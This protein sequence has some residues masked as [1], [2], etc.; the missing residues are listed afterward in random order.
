[1]LRLTGI[2]AGGG[3]SQPLSVTATSSNTG[4]IPHPV[5]NYTSASTTGSLALTPVANQSGT[6]T[7]TV[8]V[9]DGGLDNNLA[10]PGDNASFS[11]D[12]TVEVTPNETGSRIYQNFDE[13]GSPYQLIEPVVDASHGVL[14]NGPSGNYFRLNGTTSNS[15]K[16]GQP[17]LLLFNDVID[18]SNATIHASFDYR[19]TV[20]TNG[21]AEG[22][23]FTLYPADSITKVSDAFLSPGFVYPIDIGSGSAG[24]FHVH[25]DTF[26]NAQGHP[27]PNVNARE[28]NANHL[29]VNYNSDASASGWL[30]SY[31]VPYDINDGQW[32][33]VDLQ[34]VPDA[35]GALLTLTATAGNT[36]HEIVQELVIPGFDFEEDY[37]AALWADY[38]AAISLH[39][40]DNVLVEALLES[41]FSG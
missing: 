19:E 3:E 24:V 14:A 17:D 38:G 1:L 40:I 2:T 5:I 30:A 13:A 9:T 10:T 41:G 23:R 15:S 11:R 26:N 12:F 34:M 25:F 28:P 29:E 33:T 32:H 18:V 20:H 21:G 27:D 8:T 37:R 35:Q 39:D 16:N 22:L 36:T 31:T 7:I 4:L 6:A